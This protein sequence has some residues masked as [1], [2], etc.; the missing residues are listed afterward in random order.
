[1][2]IKTF[3][4]HSSSE[5]VKQPDDYIADLQKLVDCKFPIS[6]TVSKTGELLGVTYET[7]WREGSTTPVTNK[8]GRVTKH[9]ED[10]TERELTPAQIKK[11][12][13]Y[14]SENVKTA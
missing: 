4:A 5:P 3:G 7:T 6:A 8:K 14:L 13:A 10:Y 1:M 12:D 11:I 9:D 2:S